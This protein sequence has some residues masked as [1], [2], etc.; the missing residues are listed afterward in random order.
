MVKKQEAKGVNFDPIT[1]EAEPDEVLFNL[2][3]SC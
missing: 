1:I 2:I 3:I